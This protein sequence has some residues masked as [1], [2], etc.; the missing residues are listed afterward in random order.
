MSAEEATPRRR[1]D[2]GHHHGGD[3]HDRQ[4]RSGERSG[5]RSGQKHGKRG[6]SKRP[7]ERA[8]RPE[9]H[10]RPERPD[11]HE[12]PERHERPGKVASIENARPRRQHQPRPH[13][14][15]ADVAQHLPAFLLRPVR[16]KA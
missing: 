11:R 1:G 6:S 10:E 16:V 3:R 14:D 5:E 12:R 2:R 9:R 13:D 7:Q 4:D 15:E 8:D